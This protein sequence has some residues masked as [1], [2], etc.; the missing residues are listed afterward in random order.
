MK[1]A[2]H[3]NELLPVKRTEKKIKLSRSATK[4]CWPLF[5]Q[6]GITC[7]FP[8]ASAAQVTLHSS[9]VV[10]TDVALNHLHEFLFAGEALAVIAFRFKM[11]QN[12]SIGPLS[13]QW[14]TQDILCVIPACTSLWWNDLLVY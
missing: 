14:A 11:L 3:I 10:I 13:M 8:L 6:Q 1:E 4:R 7:V 9:G 5:M 12:P 2:T